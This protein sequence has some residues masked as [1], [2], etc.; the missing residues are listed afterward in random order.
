M[1][2]GSGSQVSPN[3]QVPILKE[4]LE[5]PYHEQAVKLE[6]I[7]E[8]ANIKNELA[9]DTVKQNNL[10]DM[11]NLHANPNNS[12]AENQILASQDRNK[13]KFNGRAR[14]LP[15]PFSKYLINKDK[16]YYEEH[17]KGIRSMVS[18]NS[19]GLYELI[20]D[21]G[22]PHMKTIEDIKFII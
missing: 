1:A 7:E 13:I 6:T 2:Q 20:D 9:D 10:S 12:P 4:H 3:P 8:E 19:N 15:K 5:N 14:R 16:V 18:P 11:E 21:G 17:R 22:N